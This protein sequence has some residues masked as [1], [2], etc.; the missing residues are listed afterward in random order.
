MAPEPLWTVESRKEKA[1]G[2]CVGQHWSE[3][4]EATSCE[5]CVDE[6]G[7]DPRGRCYPHWPELLEELLAKHAQ[8]GESDEHAEYARW[9][10]APEQSSI[11]VGELTDYLD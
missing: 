4:A 3:A 8:I 2:V 6:L 9:L 1:V 5:E 7:E 10:L 11:G